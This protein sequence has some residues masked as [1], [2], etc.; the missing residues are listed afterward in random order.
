M[1][2][3]QHGVHP[4]LPLL[5]YQRAVQ[6]PHLAVG[7]MPDM[8]LPAK[9]HSSRAQG[10]C[11][12]RYAVG[13]GT[14]EILLSQVYA[15]LLQSC[16]LIALQGAPQPH[17]A[18]AIQIPNL[19]STTL[20]SVGA[21]GSSFVFAGLS[22]GLCI[23]KAT[24]RLPSLGAVRLTCGMQHVNK[25]MQNIGCLLHSQHAD[26]DPPSRMCMLQ[27]IRTAMELFRACP[28]R[29]WGVLVR[30]LTSLLP[31]VSI[32]AQPKSA[33][34]TESTPRDLLPGGTQVRLLSRM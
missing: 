29:S 19:H 31:L 28:P 27:S 1:L 11:L 26:L 34:L 17:R 22:L 12:L 21:A 2:L 3:A 18:R 10:H 24:R 25:G 15:L 20:L 4:P 23:G 30:L 16:M 9:W 6:A 33:S 8:G 5:P 13:F 7:A 32:D 14:I